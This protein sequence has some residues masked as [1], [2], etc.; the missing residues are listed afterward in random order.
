LASNGDSHTATDTS[1]VRHAGPVTEPGG[2]DQGAISGAT[3][4]G[5]RDRVAGKGGW[6]PAALGEDLHKLELQFVPAWLRPTDAENRIPAAIAILVAVLLQLTVPTKYG[7]HPRWLLPSLEVA[8][9]VVLTALNPVRLSRRTKLGKYTALLV[10]AVISLDNSVSAV[11]LDYDITTGKASQDAIGLLT[12]GA[13]IYLTNI[14]AF[15]LWYWELDRGGPFTR[16]AGSRPHPDFLFPQM[17]TPEVA[18]RDWEPRFLD[19]LYV[20][21]TNVVAFSPTDT[22]PL[23]RGAKA[24]MAVQSLVALST[25]GLVVARAVNV[26]K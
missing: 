2:N 23:T 14:I 1:D 20:S 19:Y 11:L 21:F 12:S 22:M 26:L 15:G 9:L 17:S 18:P 25:I 4:L 16:A 7:L 10:V 24:L 6:A 5:W 8:L 3:G 13:A